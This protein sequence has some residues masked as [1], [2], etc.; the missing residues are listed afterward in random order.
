MEDAEADRD[1]RADLDSRLEADA[2]AVAEGDFDRTAEAVTRRLV[3]ADREAL[4]VTIALRL[5]LAVTIGLRLILGEAEDDT[6]EIESV[7]TTDANRSMLS[8]LSIFIIPL[9]LYN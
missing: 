1:T 6:V 7:V 2:D 9:Y 8:I 3:R 4:G 5:A